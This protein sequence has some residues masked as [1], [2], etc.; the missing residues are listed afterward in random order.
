MFVAKSVLFSLLALPVVELAIFIVVASLI[1]LGTALLLILCS[2]VL[3]A[4]VLRSAESSHIMRVRA[5]MGDR[6]FAA[7]QIDGT[8]VLIVIAG[9]L[10]LIPG[11]ITSVLGLALFVPALRRW[12]GA[13]L[14]RALGTGD[15]REQGVVDLAPEDWR[16][17]PEERL[18]DR[19]NEDDK[20]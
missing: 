6:E 10:L 13:T 16:Q 15:A 20:R 2:S 1:G 17:V 14:R 9:F 5:A 3:G 19:R 12:L 7:T 4:I 18:T 11:F 8:G